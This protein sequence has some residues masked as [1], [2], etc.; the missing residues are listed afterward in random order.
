MGLLLLISC[1]LSNAFA[2]SE[3]PD[4]GDSSERVLTPHKADSI[5][6]SLVRY[7]K[8][9]KKVLDDPLVSDYIN[10]L[11][12]R[13]VSASD[14]AG[15]FFQFLV[16]K[17]R[18]IN[19]F[20]APGRVIGVHTGLISIA[21][22][23]SELAAVLAHEVAHVTQRHLARFFEARKRHS[24]IA[25]VA[26]L[27]SLLVGDRELQKAA[28]VGSAAGSAQAA[29]NFTRSNEKEADNIGIKLL[30]RS[31]FDPYA[32]PKFFQRMQEASG[33]YGALIP[34]FLRTHPVSTN[35]IAEATNRINLATKYKVKHSINFH[36][37]KSRIKVLNARSND[38][39]IKDFSYQLKSG[40]TLSKI[41]ARYGLV[42]AYI[43]ANQLKRANRLLQ[44]LLVNDPA[45][46][47]YI[48]AQADIALKQKKSK[49]VIQIY[50]T[51]LDFFPKNSA[52]IYYYV[53]AMLHLNRANKAR[54]I[55][56]K[57]LAN[58]SDNFLTADMHNLY[59]LAAARSRHMAEAYQH[60]A[61]YYYQNGYLKAAVGQLLKA[62]KLRK[63][64]AILALKIDARLVLFKQELKTAETTK[65][66]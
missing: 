50:D 41:A 9:K 19:A 3:L 39:L 57:Y 5:G 54:R 16:I 45:R 49:K 26:V 58:D 52:I 61:E 29:I 43:K 31:E 23:E 13:L 20:A 25:T 17:D 34:E 37:M 64:N 65:K 53:D 56:Q 38:K 40:Y 21:K 46:L 47:A 2:D 27:A 22:S 24:L 4:I 14:G 18:S 66:H 33:S 55:F 62:T 15:Q 28:I 6:K 59:A 1:F 35:R 36:L 10:S 11:G 51:A 60:K 63:V 7:L 8:R 12:N 42:L 48:V 30:T 32:M 44:P